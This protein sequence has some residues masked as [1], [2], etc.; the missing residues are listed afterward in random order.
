LNKEEIEKI[1]NINHF[2]GRAPQQTVEFVRE[3]LEPLLAKCKN[4]GFAEKIN[5]NV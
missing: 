4:Y 5:L 3:Y 2:I 1:F